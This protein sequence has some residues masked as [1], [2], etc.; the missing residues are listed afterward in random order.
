MSKRSNSRKDRFIESIVPF[1]LED[2]WPDISSR[3]KFNFSYFDANQKHATDFTTWDEDNLQRFFSKLRSYSQYPL[4]HWQQ[5][6]I[7]SHKN[8]VLEIYGAFPRKSG[9][10]HPPHV[11]S[12]V[13]WARFR[14]DGKKRLIGFTIPKSYCTADTSFDDNTFYI[15]F[16]DLEHNFYL[17]NR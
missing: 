11:P 4:S 8:H 9:F 13:D 3:C 10:N 17:G 12:D 7:G 15:V 1:S 2:V 14:L 6:A 16:L 5:Q